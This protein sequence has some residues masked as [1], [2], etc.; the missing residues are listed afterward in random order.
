MF[1]EC[2]RYRHT[3]AKDYE[4]FKSFK[5]ISRLISHVGVEKVFKE[6]VNSSQCIKCGTIKLTV[7]RYGKND[8]QLSVENLSGKHAIEWLSQH[9][10]KLEQIKIKRQEPVIVYSKGIDLCYGKQSGNES[11]KARYCNESGT[12]DGEYLS[13]IV[14]IKEGIKH[15]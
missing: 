12:R 11:Q 3:L 13:P 8:K 6:L 2:C 1:F 9:H 4:A 15:G 10:A 14:V 7:A 5:L